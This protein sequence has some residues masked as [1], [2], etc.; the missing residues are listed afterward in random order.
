MDTLKAFNVLIESG[1]PHDQAAALV[2][3]INSPDNRAAT[4]ADLAEL[5]AEIYKALGA[6]TIVI[7]GMVVGLI[8]WMH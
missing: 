6:Q 3:V 1:M 2:D 4:K 5:K 7:G 8:K